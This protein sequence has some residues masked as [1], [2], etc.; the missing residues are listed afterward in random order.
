MRFLSHV[1]GE[2][3]LN[4]VYF[5]YKSLNKM[6]RKIQSN[7]YLPH[8]HVFHKG[9]I[10]ILVQHQLRKLNQSWDEFITSEGFDGVLINRKRGRPPHKHQSNM[11][12]GEESVRI[13]IKQIP[14]VSISMFIRAKAL[15]SSQPK[16]I[17]K[18]INEQSLNL[19]KSS[20]VERV[21][22][23]NRVTRSATNR[24]NSGPIP[25]SSSSKKLSQIHKRRKREPKMVSQVVLDEESARNVFV[26]SK[27][28]EL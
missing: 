3:E 8:Y 4:L 10:K 15:L 12:M 14:K 17:F 27:Q 11:T 20:P 25:S 5:L 2:K 23:S 19:S 26:D 28:G 16:S 21:F 18:L 24:G 6:S 13:P 7:P 22:P 9:L 1:V